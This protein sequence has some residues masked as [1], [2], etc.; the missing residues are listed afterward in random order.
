MID[1]VIQKVSPYI[2]FKYHTTVY[3]LFSYCLYSWS[4]IFRGLVTTHSCLS[5]NLVKKLFTKLN[6]VCKTDFIGEKQTKIKQIFHYSLFFRNTDQV[7]LT[8]PFLIF[9]INFRTTRLEF[10]RGRGKSKETKRYCS[11]N[12][13]VKWIPPCH[14][15]NHLSWGRSL[16]I[17]YEEP[18]STNAAR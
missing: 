4:P 7:D 9:K 8:I 11:E 5:E 1:I 12:I 15:K 10:V 6:I 17:Y 3:L 13:L 16:I 14:C 2:M 18:V